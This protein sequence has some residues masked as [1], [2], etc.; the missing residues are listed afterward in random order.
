[1]SRNIWVNLDGT[2]NR[3]NR[4]IIEKEGLADEIYL[5]NPN[6]RGFNYG[7]YQM[8]Q[9]TCG[10]WL[11]LFDQYPSKIPKDIVDGSGRL[12]PLK[13][14]WFRHGLRYQ[15]LSRHANPS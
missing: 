4:P 2:R 15:D 12:H 14:D 10:T 5:Y 9:P 7:L 13:P 3:E 8:A 11:D 6:G 1:M